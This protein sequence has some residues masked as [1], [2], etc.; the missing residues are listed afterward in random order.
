MTTYLAKLVGNHF[1]ESGKLVL[2]V[3][4]EGQDLI[5]EPEPD[6]EHDPDA[7]KVCVDM[8][9]SRFI[10]DPSQHVVVHLGYIPRSRNQNF[11]TLEVHQIMRQPDWKASLT[12]DMMGQPMVRID[13]N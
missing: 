10:K 7:I 9:G 8:F 5:L 6:N 4:G 2:P 11:G 12:F 1:R 3:L 13:V